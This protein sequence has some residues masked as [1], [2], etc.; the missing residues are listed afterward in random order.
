MVILWYQCFRISSSNYL[1]E[2]THA[3]GRV[4]FVCYCMR[5]S[6]FKRRV[7]PKCGKRQSVES[8]MGK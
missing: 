6:Q 7:Q 8:K 2:G 1:R 4:F 5:A 3:I